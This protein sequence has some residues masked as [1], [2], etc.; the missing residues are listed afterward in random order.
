MTERKKKIKQEPY[1]MYYKRFK[2]I[3]DILTPVNT[4]KHKK[5]EYLNVAS[6]FDTETSSFYLNKQ[7]KA[8]MYLWGFGINGK[9]YV[10]RTYEELKRVLFKVVEY[11]ELSLSKRIVVYVHNLAYD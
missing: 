7:K 6:S 9:V 10:G 11:Y 2:N 5:I 1:K 3:E 4:Y 8:C